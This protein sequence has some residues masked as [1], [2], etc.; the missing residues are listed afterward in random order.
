M[1][2]EQ[3]E[4]VE[5][6]EVIQRFEVIEPQEKKKVVAGAFEYVSFEEEDRLAALGLG[7]GLLQPPD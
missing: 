3:L 7:A 5:Q 6:F 1:V 2:L 4:V